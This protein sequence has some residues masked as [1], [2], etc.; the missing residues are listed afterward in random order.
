MAYWP[1][2]GE[3][4]PGRSDRQGRWTHRHSKD[5]RRQPHVEE[6][7]QHG[8]DDI[9]EENPERD[10]GTFANAQFVLQPIDPLVEN[11]RQK[12]RDGDP[13]GAKYAPDCCVRN[14]V[15]GQKLW[16]RRIEPKQAPE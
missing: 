15:I 12:G 2:K 4:K 8:E 5:P 10:G 13:N 1:Y 7:P 9:G 6:E 16:G 14:T 11:G 3:R